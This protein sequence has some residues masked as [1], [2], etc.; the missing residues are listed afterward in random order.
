M[1][2]Y[3]CGWM[4]SLEISEK[5]QFQEKKKSTKGFGD[6]TSLPAGVNA[7]HVCVFVCVCVCV[8]V[9]VGGCV[10]VGVCVCECILVFFGAL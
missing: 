9:C 1:D 3:L 4:M 10:C 2:A 5:Q 6:Q 7:H 8:C